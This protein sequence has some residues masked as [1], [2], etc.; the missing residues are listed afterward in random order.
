MVK[1]SFCKETIE[2]GTGSMFVKNDGT[3]LNFCSTKCQKSLMKLKRDS[4]KT[5]WT[6]QYQK[7]KGGKK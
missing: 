6:K 2:K 1:C 7:K 5:P 3:L 4:A